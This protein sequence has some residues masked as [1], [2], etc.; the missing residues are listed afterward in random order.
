MARIKGW[1]K[2]HD[3]DQMI[4]YVNKNTG[5]RLV[6]SKGAD[7][8][9]ASTTAHQKR[10]TKEAARQDAIWYMRNRPNG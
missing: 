5:R 9:S 2:E 3:N 10:P 4:T 6:V 1:R 7:G 8:W